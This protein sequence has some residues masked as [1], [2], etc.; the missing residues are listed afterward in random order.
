MF[1]PMRFARFHH[2]GHQRLCPTLLVLVVAVLLPPVQIGTASSAGWFKLSID[3]TTPRAGEPVT[4]RVQTFMSV[5]AQ[6][7]NDPK[8][9]P[10]PAPVVSAAEGLHVPNP[11]LETIGPPGFK[12]NATTKGGSIGQTFSL[13][14][15]QS[16]PTVW[17]AKITFDVPGTWR[18][19]I[20]YPHFPALHVPDLCTGAAILVTVLPATSV[21][22]AASPVASP[23][24]TPAS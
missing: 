22:P 3:P 24:A 12:V 17:E 14:R 20:V 6:C 18:L 8:A 19:M 11:K 13:H 7:M 4:V 16:D 15:S 9:T 23:T 1:R 10:I 21:I 2:S 5:G